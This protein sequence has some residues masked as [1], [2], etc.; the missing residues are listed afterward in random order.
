MSGSTRVWWLAAALAVAAGV[1]LALLRKPDSV[2]VPEPQPSAEAPPSGPSSSSPLPAPYIAPPDQAQAWVPPGITAGQ[3]AALKTELAAQ[4]QELRRLQ[5]HYVF[6]D[7]VRRFRA[8]AA[9][10]ERRALAQR[11]DAG[12]DERLQAGEL[13]A[14]EARLLKLAA[15][16]ELQPDEAARALALSQWETALAA[17]PAPA[18]VQRAQALDQDFQRRQQALLAAW[19]ARPAA[20][21]DPNQLERELDAL[22]VAVYRQ[23]PR[24]SP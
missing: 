16:R 9:G 17:Q 19:Q 2:R 12:L 1:G 3:W 4:P 15:L 8:Q 13:S 10:D 20:E 24:R 5:A 7:Q 6:A 18:D 14:G 22:R 11:I 21:R 23:Q